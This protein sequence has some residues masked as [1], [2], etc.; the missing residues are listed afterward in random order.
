LQPICEICVLFES[1]QPHCPACAH[2]QRRAR[3]L[4]RELAGGLVALFSV[5][6]VGAVGYVVTRDKP[7][8]YGVRTIKVRALDEQ[9]EREPCD[10]THTVE[11]TETMM[12]AGDY[13]GALVRARAFTTRCGA[14][15]RLLWVTYAAHQRLSEYDAAIADASMLITNHPEDKD[16]WWWRGL[17]YEERGELERAV[18]DFRQALRIEP[19]LTGVPFNLANVLERLHRPCEAKQPIEQFLR[20]HPEVS[21]LESA[22]RRLARLEAACLTETF[23]PDGTW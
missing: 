23:R 10:R 8:D 18:A 9:L 4:R 1:T 22:Q 20:R 13:R 7:F 11:L 6:F 2:K 17:V 21:D 16:F 5:A 14:Y 15:D 12:A 19:R 3:K